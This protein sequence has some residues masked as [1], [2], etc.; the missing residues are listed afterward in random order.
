MASSIA[1]AR[2]VEHRYYTVYTSTCK[3]AVDP[4]ARLSLVRMKAA[5]QDAQQDRES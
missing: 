5:A 3:L 2:T 4:E 1:K